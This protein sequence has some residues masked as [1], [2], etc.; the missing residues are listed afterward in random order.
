M[1]P[2][3]VFWLILCT[4]NLVITISMGS[5]VISGFAGIAL[6]VWIAVAIIENIL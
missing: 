2:K 1:R 3:T 4:T 6:G 5:V